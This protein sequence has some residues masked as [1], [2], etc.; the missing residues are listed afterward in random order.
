MT[1]SEQVSQDTEQSLALC[2][3]LASPGQLKCLKRLLGGKKKKKS[4]LMSFLILKFK[5]TTLSQKK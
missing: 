5:N 4:H 2:E 3:K 1:S